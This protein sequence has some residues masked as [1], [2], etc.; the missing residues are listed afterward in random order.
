M[1]KFKLQLHS[2]SK[3]K[4]NCLSED[5]ARNEEDGEGGR[6]RKKNNY[7]WMRLMLGHENDKKEKFPHT[8]PTMLQ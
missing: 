3:F 2:Q 8:S 4:K 1:L 6:K 7:D 5:I